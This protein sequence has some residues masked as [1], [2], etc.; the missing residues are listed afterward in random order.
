MNF[1]AHVER[2]RVG[3]GVFLGR[4]ELDSLCF[5]LGQLRQRFALLRDDGEDD[6]FPRILLAVFE[7]RDNKPRRTM[8][9]HAAL[10]IRLAI[11]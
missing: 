11:E 5:F 6:L 4:S 9:L 10:S 7:P 3:R 2:T 8:I 1:V